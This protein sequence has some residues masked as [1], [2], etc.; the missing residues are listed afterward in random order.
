MMSLCLRELMEDMPLVGKRIG[1]HL[2][3]LIHT[4]LYM[5]LIV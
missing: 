1:Y 3:I 4:K 2:Y 5:V